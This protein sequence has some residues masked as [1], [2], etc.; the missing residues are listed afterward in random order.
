VSWGDTNL[1]LHAYSVCKYSLQPVLSYPSWWCH[2]CCSCVSAIRLHRFW[3]CV[4]P[5]SVKQITLWFLGETYLVQHRR[6]SIMRTSMLMYETTKPVLAHTDFPSLNPLHNGRSFFQSLAAPTLFLA[7]SRYS[8]FQ[9]P[10]SYLD[11]TC[12]VL[13]RWSVPSS[14][15][16]ISHLFI[17]CH[18]R[19]YGT[20]FYDSSLGSEHFGHRIIYVVGFN[21]CKTTTEPIATRHNFA[22]HWARRFRLLCSPELFSIRINMLYQIFSVLRAAIRTCCNIFFFSLNSWLIIYY[23]YLNRWNPLADFSAIS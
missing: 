22:W 4:S 17:I 7:T 1:D 23:I 20:S 2:C 5:L 18:L 15:L 9:S 3:N 6:I 14:D 11:V 19:V 21:A 8:V 10:M 16:Y 12:T 13:H